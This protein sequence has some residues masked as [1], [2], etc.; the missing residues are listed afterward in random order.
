M[1]LTVHARFAT[2]AVAEGTRWVGFA[3][4]DEDEDYALFAQGTR[5]GPVRFEV[6]DPLFTAEDAVV[7][8]TVGADALRVELNP[9]QAADFGFARVVVV[10][11]A[12]GADGRDAALMAL[13]KMLGARVI[14]G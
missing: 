9:A 3:E 11:L 12:P 7:S 13:R 1:D 14:D 4:G 8:V 6:N 2:V 10:R 5:G